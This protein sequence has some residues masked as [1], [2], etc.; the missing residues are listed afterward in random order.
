ML[1]GPLINLLVGVVVG[2]AAGYVFWGG[3]K[4]GKT[5]ELEAFRKCE[6]ELLGGIYNT[7]SGLGS[8]ETVNKNLM[9]L[10]KVHEIQQKII[11]VLSSQQKRQ[12]IVNQVLMTSYPKMTEEKFRGLNE[13]N[14]SIQKQLTDIKIMLAR[15]LKAT[16]HKPVV[17]KDTKKLKGKKG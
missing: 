1:G 9:K 5:S 10:D 4:D 12:E 17:Y 7:I 15:A 13:F 8:I 6:L 11:E 14:V 2:I 3:K 16:E